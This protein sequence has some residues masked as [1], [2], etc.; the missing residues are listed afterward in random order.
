MSQS[1]LTVR[2]LASQEEYRVYYRLADAAFSATPSEEDAHSWFSALLR[3]PDFR[4]EQVRG[5][6]RDGQQLGGYLL[7]E[8]MLRMGAA[9]IPTGCLG[10]V[11]TAVE[12][13][14]QGVA[15]ALMQDALAVA[16][17]EQKPLLLLDGIPNFY[18]RYGYTNIF[19]VTAIEVN[20]SAILAQAPTEYTVRPASIDDAPAL[21]DLY[22]SHFN[23]YTGSFDRS[24]ELQLHR[25]REGRVQYVVALSAQGD[26][27]GYLLPG[28]DEEEVLQ[29]REIAANS[30]G[31]LLALLQYHAHLFDGAVEPATLI[32]LLP[33]NSPMTHWLIDTLEVPD[34]STWHSLM[35]KW[36]VRTLTYHHRFTG[37]M[38]CLVNFPLLMQTIL[39]E[40]QA[41]WQRSL[42]Q[43]S[44]EI[45]LVVGEETCVL[46]VHEGDVQIVE[47]ASNTALRI[48]LTPQA[49]VRLVFGYRRLPELSAASSLLSSDERTVLQVL[50]PQG[51]TWIAYSDWF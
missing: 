10:A 43:W 5:A 39:P 4:A 46:R 2:S 12:A 26:I 13:R 35:H 32:Y 41:R 33:A 47:D 38:A 16:R 30:W 14:K 44:G 15:S 48:P 24:L 17:Q 25:L 3:S 45:A 23:L 51:H 20:R 22:Q 29:G 11:A 28:K 8:R 50:F 6:F 37:W 49:L 19:D 34:T 7:H 21:F 42:V 40:L 31:A 1:L 18:F 27:E 36:G 9:L